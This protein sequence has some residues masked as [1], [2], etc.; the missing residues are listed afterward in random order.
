ME[1]LVVD[2]NI[3]FLHALE[4]ALSRR[5]VETTALSDCKAAIY[6]AEITPIDI[7]VS[8]YFM[9][10]MDGTS[11]LAEI[12]KYRPM[13]ELILTSTFPLRILS[14][15][16][17]GIQFVQKTDLVEAICRLAGPLCPS[18]EVNQ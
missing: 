11:L 4:L 6:H 5:G 14:P 15:S 17:L 8:D 10:G 13:C 7:A 9:P 12:K 2:D 16:V 1:V 18:F 3:Q